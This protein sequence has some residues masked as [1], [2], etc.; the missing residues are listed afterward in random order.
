MLTHH[1][2]LLTCL[3]HQLYTIFM[4]FGII[5]LLHLIILIF[6]LKN[7]IANIKCDFQSTMDFYFGE[8]IYMQI[9]TT[10]ALFID[11]IL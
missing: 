10:L 1:L 8:Y 6:V 2:L 4:R 7:I 11:S 9:L 5:I 3:I